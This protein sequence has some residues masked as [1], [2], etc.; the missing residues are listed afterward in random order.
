MV[1]TRSI[2]LL[3]VLLTGLEGTKTISY[4]AEISRCSIRIQ[5]LQ[6]DVTLGFR[7]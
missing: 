5:Q 4:D 6:I 3:G 1:R 7:D 2:F